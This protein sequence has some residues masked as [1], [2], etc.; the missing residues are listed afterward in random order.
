MFGNI[1]SGRKVLLTG[2][3][4]FK[5]SWLAF[6]LKQLGAEVCGVG[7]EMDGEFSHFGLLKPEIRSEIFD[8]R[9]RRKLETLF[10]EFQPEIVFH[11]AAQPLVRLSYLDPVE[12]FDINVTGSACVLD[13]CRKSAG[14]RAI[15]AITSDKCYENR[16]TLTP[17]TE[18]D[19]MGGYDPYSASKGCAEL[20]ISSYRRSFFNVADYGK[21][22]NTLLASARAGNVVGG[23]DWAR[24]RLVPDLMLGAASGRSAVIRNPLAVRPW[25]HVLEPLSGYLALGAEL[26][27]GNTQFA[28]A[29][30]FGPENTAAVTVK[31]A[32]E[33]L[34]TGWDALNYEVDPPPDAPHEANL[35]LLDASK[36]GRELG[37]HGIWD[38]RETLE[39]TARWYRDFY[40]TNRINT[41]D[42]LADYISCAGSKGLKW[43]R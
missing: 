10:S 29:Y 19:P 1:Y 8:I 30:N 9:D 5:G 6:W 16:E 25:Q 34:K 24:D 28:S 22:H 23:G 15:V 12:T 20:V 4:G 2:H 38:V 42:D 17:Y 7:L 13:A 33:F 18:S 41:M 3:T 31:E 11:L 36:A 43:T 14:C 40:C 26:L 21:K 32:A 35:L 27:S 39:R 37:W